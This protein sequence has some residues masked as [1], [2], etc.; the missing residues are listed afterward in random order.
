[1]LVLVP[2]WSVYVL[3]A[4]SYLED[5]CLCLYSLLSLSSHAIYTNVVTIFLECSTDIFPSITFSR[6]LSWFMFWNS[7]QK[8]HSGFPFLKNILSNNF[9]QH[10]R[11][12]WQEQH[13]CH[14]N[15]L[16][17]PVFFFCLF[18]SQFLVDILECKHHH[19]ITASFWHARHKIKC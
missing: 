17:L 5:Y 11:M 16:T 6:P 18:V 14:S 2:S 13:F 10:N 8:I 7:L 15:W 3:T 4:L 12:R 9:H 19:L 1:M